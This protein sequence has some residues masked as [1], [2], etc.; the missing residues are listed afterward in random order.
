[1]DDQVGRKERRGIGDR[2]HRGIVGRD[3]DE[4]LV[5][6]ARQIGE[7]QRQEAVRGACERQRCRRRRDGGENVGGGTGHGSGI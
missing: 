1:M 2:L 4:P 5:A 3:I 6:G 7:Q